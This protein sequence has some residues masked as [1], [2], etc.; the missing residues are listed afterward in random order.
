MHEAL[1]EEIP[2]FT[3]LDLE[4]V[5]RIGSDLVE[6][7]LRDGH[8]VTICAKIG[9][10]RVFHAALPGTS[11]DNDAWVDRKL[12]VVE[13]FG[14]PSLMVQERYASSPSDFYR[15]F[16]LDPALFAPAGGAVPLIAAGV[17][18]G[19]L[20][21]S[22]LASEDDHGIALAALRRFSDSTPGEPS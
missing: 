22:G 6:R 1:A 9:Q 17:V 14:V 3:R 5:W 15:D 10:Q 18:V 21:V 13:R 12:R 20:A 2:E 4:V 16:G 19:G 11:A 8:A 7:C